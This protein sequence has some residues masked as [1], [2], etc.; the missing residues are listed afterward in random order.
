M[1]NR[2]AKTKLLLQLPKK[3]FQRATKS[4]R[5]IRFEKDG[6]YAAASRSIAIDVRGPYINGEWLVVAQAST[7]DD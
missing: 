2:T 7:V 6:W 3:G 5:R 1:G 4:R